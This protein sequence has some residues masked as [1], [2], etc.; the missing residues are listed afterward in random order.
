MSGKWK[1]W[2]K[3][4]ETYMKNNY[5]NP[6]ITIDEIRTNLKDRTARSISGKANE[7]GCYRPPRLLQISIG[8][9]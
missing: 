9:K 8:R 1:R 4:E 2:T 7:M 3:Q 6:L 5:H